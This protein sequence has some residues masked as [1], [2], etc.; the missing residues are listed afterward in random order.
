MD[1]SRLSLSFPISSRKHNCCYSPKPVPLWLGGGADIPGCRFPGHFEL[2]VASLVEEGA[3]QSLR[4]PWKGGQQVG[5]L[6]APPPTGLAPGSHV[7]THSHPPLQP[8]SSV[9]GPETLKLLLLKSRHEGSEGPLESP[10][11]DW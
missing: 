5:R 8:K 7:R 4:S 1:L 9:G 3:S 2:G 10:H 6:R 11:P